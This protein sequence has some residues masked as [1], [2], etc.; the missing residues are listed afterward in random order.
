M[1]RH[2]VSVLSRFRAPDNT[3]GRLS[4]NSEQYAAFQSERKTKTSITWSLKESKNKILTV[5][6]LNSFATP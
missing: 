4:L 5:S 3:V 6:S 2:L 1:R